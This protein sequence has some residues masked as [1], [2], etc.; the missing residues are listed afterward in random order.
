MLPGSATAEATAAYAA[1]HPE[2]DYRPLGKTGLLVSPAGFGTYRV[3][4]HSHVFHEALELALRQ[5][6]NLIDTS[7]NYADGSSE[8]LVGAV[9]RR[10]D[11]EGGVP[12]AAVVAVSKGGY[13]QG[14]NYQISQQ[15]QAGGK[16][17]PDLVPYAPGLAHSIH[18]DF[19]RDQIGRSLQ[20]LQMATLDG[21]LL[22]NPEYYLSWARR[23]GKGLHAA[24]E[25]YARRIA[26]AFAYLEEEV[27]RGRIRW[28]GISSNSFPSPA[29]DPAHT[30]LAAVWELAEQLGPEHHFR[31][32][33]LP[34]N[35]L[36]TGAVTERNQP[37]GE[38]VLGL[39]QALGLAV[40]INRPLN[41]IRE[42]RLLR[43]A[44]VTVEGEPDAARAA[45]AAARLRKREERFRDEILPELPAPASMAQQL[46][47]V[48][49]VGQLLEQRWQHFDSYQNW[50][51]VQTQVLVPR[52]QAGLDYLSKQEDLPPRAGEWLGKYVIAMNEALRAVTH[53]YQA[54]AAETAA[55]LREQAAVADAA[56]ADAP[57]LSQLGLR[58]LRSTA[59]VTSVLVGMRHQV[60]VEDVLA[61]LRRPVAVA[62]RDEAWERLAQESVSR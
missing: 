57:S 19:L 61:E 28:Y 58:A 40:L 3:D 6:I 7:A 56:W 43:L 23:E 47:A 27:Q 41:A 48:F 20:R 46:L 24:R 10:L 60:Y 29:S 51:E 9:L 62:A 11:E 36:E 44:D 31:A 49:S 17:W 45:S 2:I 34:F 39:A 4:V 35:L 32:I 22:H 21:Y 18:P 12:R 15:R 53:V 38:S 16:G 50:L 42:E 13:I 1:A 55:A 37:G 26:L 59:G 33:Q 52:V 54:Q 25:E 5:G 8:E 14:Q 30:S